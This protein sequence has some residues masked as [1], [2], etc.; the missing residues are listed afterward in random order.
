MT[1]TVMV[2]LNSSSATMQ[3]WIGATVATP[4]DLPRH[5]LISAGLTMPTVIPD[6]EAFFWTP[7]WQAGER[8]SEEDYLAGRSHRFDTVDEAIRYLLRAEDSSD[9]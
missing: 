4:V 7:R 8:A 3:E 2:E 6:D 5:G 9:L 1:A